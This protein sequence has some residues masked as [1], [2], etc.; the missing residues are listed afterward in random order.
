MNFNLNNKISVKLTD[1]GYQRRA[2]IHNEFVGKIRNWKERDLG[3][4]KNEAEKN[5][6]YTVMQAWCFMRDFG[7]DNTRID[8]LMDINI[9]IE[10]GKVVFPRRRDFICHNCHKNFSSVDYKPLCGECGGRNE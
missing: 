1:K 3:Y 8:E 5:D 4:Y 9:M 2:D 6:G 10:E 7:G